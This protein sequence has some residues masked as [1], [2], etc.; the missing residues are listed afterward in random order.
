MYDNPSP[1]DLSLLHAQI[2]ALED[3][4]AHYGFKYGLTDEARRLLAVQPAGGAE[5]NRDR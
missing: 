3:E 1:V 4:L 2:A 5:S